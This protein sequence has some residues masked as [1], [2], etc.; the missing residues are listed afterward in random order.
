MSRAA[1]PQWHLRRVDDAIAA[2]SKAEKEAEGAVYRVTT[3]AIGPKAAQVAIL[4][5]TYRLEGENHGRST[6]KKQESIPGH[7]DLNVFLYFWDTRD[8]LEFP[9][10]HGCQGTR[11]GRPSRSRAH[12]LPSRLGLSRRFASGRGPRS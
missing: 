7:P 2:L 4:T 5:G 6:F 8:G 11:H 10:R 12:A 1:P 9:G 3:Q